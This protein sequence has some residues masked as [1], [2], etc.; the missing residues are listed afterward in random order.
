MDVEAIRHA[1]GFVLVH[2]GACSV[3]G[4][5]H[6]RGCHPSI[7]QKAFGANRVGIIFLSTHARHVRSLRVQT[8][9]NRQ[10]TFQL[11]R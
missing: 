2:L 3:F 9:L 10:Q 5:L 6:F 8:I 1:V 4:A 7:Q 11:P